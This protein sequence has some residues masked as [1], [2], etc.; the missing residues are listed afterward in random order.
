MMKWAFS[1]LALLAIASGVFVVIIFNTEP[2][3]DNLFLLFSFFSCL[4]LI[5]F[6]FF[7]L[8]GIALVKISRRR[9]KMS[10]LARRALILGA[11]ATGLVALSSLNVLNGLSVVSLILTAVMLEAFFFTKARERDK[12]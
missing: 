2:K 4:L 7:S 8:L 1:L 3:S 5:T 10:A 6:S 11:A 12:V 9:A